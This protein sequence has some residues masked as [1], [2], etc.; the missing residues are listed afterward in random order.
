[1]CC[2]RSTWWGALRGIDGGI[3]PNAPGSGGSHPRDAS[4]TTSVDGTEGTS[5]WY[6][7]QVELDR[8]YDDVWGIHLYLWS[9]WTPYNKNLWIYLSATTDWYSTGTLCLKAAHL[10]VGSP[11]ANKIPCAFKNVRYVI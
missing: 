4:C 8:S 11:E 10:L 6:G 7:M 1:M 3:N 9:G 2:T 5:P